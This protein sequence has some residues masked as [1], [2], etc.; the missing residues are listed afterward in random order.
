MFCTN[1][2][3]QVPDGSQFCT[4]CGAPIKQSMILQSNSS[5][6]Q[7]KKKMFTAK[8]FFII[9]SCVIAGFIV[10]SA[11]AAFSGGA[12]LAKVVINWLLGLLFGLDVLAFIAGIII[13]IVYLVKSGNEQGDMKS[14][15]QKVAIWWFVGPI[16]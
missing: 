11:I 10:I 1:C 12:T 7:V 8:T 3:K 9:F 4:S 2:G 13:G 6:V 15:Y 5:V 16:L 14:H